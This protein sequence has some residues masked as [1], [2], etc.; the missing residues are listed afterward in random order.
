MHCWD[1]PTHIEEPN[2]GAFTSLD[3]YY[4]FF[5]YT[6][7]GVENFG[8]SGNMIN[9]DVTLLQV[10]PLSFY[11]CVLHTFTPLLLLYFKKYLPAMAPNGRYLYISIYA[12]ILVSSCALYI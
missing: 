1:L 6:W 3:V 4:D 12:K 9:K 8:R 11:G 10:A 5:G 2:L 7:N